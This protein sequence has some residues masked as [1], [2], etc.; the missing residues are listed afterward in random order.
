MSFKPVKIVKNLPLFVFAA[1]YS[2]IFL[3]AGAILLKNHDTFFHIH[4]DI[5]HA[6]KDI[7]TSY[8]RFETVFLQEIQ[9]NASQNWPKVF[10]NFSKL[11]ESYR[12]F[13]NLLD[14]PSVTKKAREEITR[15]QKRLKFYERRIK[16]SAIDQNQA[17]RDL[18]LLSSQIPYF[19]SKALEKGFSIPKHYNDHNLLKKT[20]LFFLVSFLCGI[21]LLF[22]LLNN[23]KTRQ[24]AEKEKKKVRALIERQSQAFETLQ[25]GFAILDPEGMYIYSNPAHAQ[26]YGHE[27]SAD[28]IGTHWSALY[29]KEKLE[30]FQGSVF[31]ILKTKGQWRGLTEGL[32][33][34]GSTFP[35][36]ISLAMFPDSSITCLVRD[37]TG[38]QDEQQKRELWLAAIEATEDGIGLIDKDLN[39]MYMNKALLH[40]HA[41][42]PKEKEEFIGTPWPSLYNEVGQEQ[43]L[44]KVIPHVRQHGAWRG[45]IPV[46][47]Q[48]DTVFWSECSLTALKG[49]NMVGVIRDIEERKKNEKEKEDL[50]S[51]LYQAQKLEAVGRLAGGIAHDFNNILAAIMGY[52]EFIIEDAEDE[53]QKEFAEK[54][55]QAGEQ[56]KDLVDQML[57]FSR[58]SDT[59]KNIV[60]VASLIQECATMLKA[61]LPKSITC[62]S[63]VPNRRYSVFANATQIKQIIM[64][65]CVNA[66]DAIGDR[67]KG[68]IAIHLSEA[69]FKNFPYRRYMVVDDLPDYKEMPTA[70]IKDIAGKNCLLTGF[71]Q[72]ETKYFVLE[73]EDTGCGMS[74][75]LMEKIF[76]PFFTT[77]PVHKG[78]GLGLS[79]VHGVIIDHKGAMIVE[80]VEGAGTK[81]S[82][83]F[84]VAIEKEKESE[85]SDISALDMAENPISVLV[86]DDQED[87]KDVL[88]QKV[89][90]LGHEAFSTASP[91][92]ALDMIRE[93]PDGIDLVLT[94]YN[95]PEMTGLELALEVEQDFPDLP[96]VIISGY[97]NKKIG[98]IT[99]RC[100]SIKGCLRKPAGKIEL[101]KKIHEIITAQTEH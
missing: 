83:Y 16:E 53:S 43:I 101:Q 19:K 2:L 13:Y 92:E 20:A 98:E 93:N 8:D 66:R 50:Q 23:W 79:T 57:T 62:E 91:L 48:D 76:E 29:T 34:D 6:I 31:P 24:K 77:K 81:F 39:L 36:E 67:K 97:S 44:N 18:V 78:T 60:D 72:K 10:Y 58:R 82:I 14:D 59:A 5:S 63:Q 33:K 12:A 21:T 47:R 54:V 96:F 85:E 9:S 25:D 38:E 61:S 3:L 22:L 73:V 4:H 15:F 95:M 64:N 28:L 87:V 55:Y 51:Q 42:D 71:L 94:D 70:R 65:L 17:I 7:E 75:E 68:R 49:G 45:E 86:V 88:V 100:A 52:T 27:N 1:I 30:W 99:E 37:L 46:M 84:P 41:I 80:S 90:R 89:K 40:H 69:N 74:L 35:Q 32:R 56:A 11:Q 26:I